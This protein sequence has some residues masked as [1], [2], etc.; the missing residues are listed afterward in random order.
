MPWPLLTTSLDFD[1]LVI[2]QQIYSPI[3]STSAI[4]VQYTFTCSPWSHISGSDYVAF[5]SH[6][7]DFRN[8]SGG[9]TTVPANVFTS[10][11]IEFGPFIHHDSGTLVSPV[12]YATP[13]ALNFSD[14]G[15]IAY[16]PESAQPYFL[17]MDGGDSLP[18]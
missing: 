13:G 4:K 12:T 18:R 6:T 2:V 16:T 7:L 15:Y 14:L 10:P 5:D 17:S 3:L 1:E 8:Q 9:S 11:D